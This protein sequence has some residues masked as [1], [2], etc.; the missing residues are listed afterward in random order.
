MELEARLKDRSLSIAITDPFHLD[1]AAITVKIGELL[2][3]QGVSM[4]GVDVEGLVPMMVRG[5]AGCEAGCPAD[6]KGLVERGY[7]NF[8]LEYIEGGILTAQAEMKVG[9]TLVLKLFPDF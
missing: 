8:R 7:R 5:V 4:T 3:G 6:A 9:G 1:L 2:A